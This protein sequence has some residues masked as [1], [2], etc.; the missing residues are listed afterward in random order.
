M[1]SFH[2]DSDSPCLNHLVSRICNAITEKQDA[3]ESISEMVGRGPSG[4]RGVSSILLSAPGYDSDFALWAGPVFAMLESG[5]GA[6]EAEEIVGVVCFHPGYRTPDGNSFPGFGHMHSLPRLR[7]WYHD[8]TPAEHRP[9]HP[10][11]DDDVAAGGAYQRRTPHAVVNVLR[12]DQLEVAEGL[13]SSGELYERNIRVLVGRGGVGLERL[14]ADLEEE[15]SL[16][17]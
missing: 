4:R 16:S 3:W 15:R 1:V 13:R 7:K 8:L 5:V 12:A 14:E 9:A 10:L 11:T 2:R 6:V 17:V